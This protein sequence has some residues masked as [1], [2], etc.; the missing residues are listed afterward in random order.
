MIYYI[1][2]L[3]YW[4]VVA[5]GA[6]MAPSTRI[7]LVM[8]PYQG[9]SMPFTYEGIIGGYK[10]SQTTLVFLMREVH[11]S[12]CHISKI[13]IGCGALESNQVPSAYETD[14]MPFL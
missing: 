4:F 14:E 7:E 10:W 6:R 5:Y 8:D 3:L 11:K 1:S 2:Y 12:L 9:P 13:K